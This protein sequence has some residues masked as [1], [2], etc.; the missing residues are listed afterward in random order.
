MSTISENSAYIILVNDDN[1]MTVTRKKRIVQRSK[2]IDDLWFLVNQNYGDYNMADFTVM[3][4]DLSPVSKKY[5]TEFLVKNEDTYNKK[6][7]ANRENGKKGGRPKKSALQDTV[8]TEF[9]V[10]PVNNIPCETETENKPVLIPQ[11]IQDDNQYQEEVESGLNSLKMGN[12][13]IIENN[14]Y[15]EEKPVVKIAANKHSSDTE[16]VQELINTDDDFYNFYVV[17]V[18]N[19]DA[20]TKTTSFDFSNK[21][22]NALENN[23][24]FI[25]K[26]EDSQIYKRKAVS[27]R[28]ITRP[29]QNMLP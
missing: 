1:S 8:G 29:V 25:I 20:N 7:N 19:V 2:L 14:T 26:N 6:V 5:R 4:E 23:V 17:P 22:K 13:E 18:I 10:T 11:I 27:Y 15:M 24:Y 12:I 9:D 28:T 16:R 3:L 21:Y